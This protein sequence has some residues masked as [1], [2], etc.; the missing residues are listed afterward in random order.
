MNVTFTIYTL[1]KNGKWAWVFDG[2]RTLEDAEQA[3]WDIEETCESAD[4]V[5]TYKI[6]RIVSYEEEVKTIA[7]FELKAERVS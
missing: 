1:E 3:I 7:S 4:I 6:V 5:R 2:Y